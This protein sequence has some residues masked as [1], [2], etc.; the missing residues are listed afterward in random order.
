MRHVILFLLGVMTFALMTE[1]KTTKSPTKN[2]NGISCLGEN[3]KMTYCENDEMCRSKY[4]SSDYEK[5]KNKKKLTFEC[6]SYEKWCY[7]T[8]NN[9]T[10]RYLK[11]VGKKSIPTIFCCCDGQGGDPKTCPSDKVFPAPTTT[12]TTSSTTSTT[13]TTTT[14]S[15]TMLPSKEK[16]LVKR[17]WVLF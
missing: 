6:K 3:D 8:Q 16:N 14:T 9:C 1:A 7:G 2:L 12:P 4:P 15:T 17:G 13:T 10:E 11:N 5:V